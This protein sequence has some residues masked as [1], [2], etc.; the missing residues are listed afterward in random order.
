M[1]RPATLES[2]RPQASTAGH[3]WCK[4]I[5]WIR[6]EEGI[7]ERASS[8][9]SMLDAKSIR[10]NSRFGSRAKLIASRTHKTRKI[11]SFD[12]LKESAI[13]FQ[14][15][16]DNVAVDTQYREPRYVKRTAVFQPLMDII[17]MEP[18]GL[19]NDY[20]DQGGQHWSVA[21]RDVEWWGSRCPKAQERPLAL[22]DADFFN[23]VLSSGPR[24]RGG[25]G[26][27]DEVQVEPIFADQ[28]AG[29]QIGRIEIVQ[30]AVVNQFHLR[31]LRGGH[32]RDLLAHM[33]AS[34]VV[35]NIIHHTYNQPGKEN[36]T[37]MHT[38]WIGKDAEPTTH[39]GIYVPWNLGSI[40][41]AEW[42]QKMSQMTNMVNRRAGSTNWV[43]RK[44]K[45]SPLFTLGIS[46]PFNSGLLY[47]AER[48]HKMT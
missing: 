33:V 29:L 44:M 47:K 32:V 8:F 23:A 22:S 9:M 30:Q 13:G 34:T 18:Q 2:T 4:R 24:Q 41:K 31:T 21:A 20:V 43:N 3:Q 16:S 19:E 26:C 46:F 37:E 12:G 40:D 15:Q 39:S 11:R 6:D 36:P 14:P 17:G 10:R 38:S 5:Y 42:V 45:W 1:E 35:L 28:G 48:V 27:V 7:V 25:Y